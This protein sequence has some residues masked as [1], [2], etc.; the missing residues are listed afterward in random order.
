MPYHDSGPLLHSNPATAAAA[1]KVGLGDS[2]RR[3]RTGR[4]EPAGEATERVDKANFDDDVL[5]ELSDS[6]THLI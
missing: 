3:Q 1:D 6:Q 5:L 2:R 4:G